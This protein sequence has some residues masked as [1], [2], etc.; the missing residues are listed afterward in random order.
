M[1]GKL[2]DDLTFGPSRR[3]R[4][5]RRRLRELDRVDAR[6]GHSTSLTGR[7]RHG[8]ERLRTVL[9]ALGTTVLVTGA[10]AFQRETP[11]GTPPAV[12]TGLGSF[13]FTAHQPGEPSA[14]VAYSP[15]RVIEIEVNDAT[16]PPAGDELL[17]RAL[18]DVSRA[19][20]LRLDVVGR[21]DEIPEP[22]RPRGVA[23]HW[24]PVLVAWATAAEVPDLAGSVAGVAGSVAVE[25]NLGGSR[26]VTGTVALDA[27]DLTEMLNQPGG[28]RQVEAIIKHELGHLVG[29][30]HVD[31]PGELMYAENVGRADFGP[32]DLE[33]LAAL[34]RGRC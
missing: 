6:G 5:M 1:R 33:G 14:P 17:A 29:L 22:E 31:D 20:G 2:L 15:C 23:G 3:R 30:D 19:T 10:V 18:D 8:G 16:A 9:V 13:A 27:A 28:H 7:G 12:E 24:E 26:Y 4:L 32:G 25:G 21:T 34:G 11:L